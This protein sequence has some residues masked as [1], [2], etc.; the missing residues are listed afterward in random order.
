MQVLVELFPAVDITR[1]GGQ[2]KTEIR[3]LLAG[4]NFTYR[5]TATE[6]MISISGVLR[7]KKIQ[8]A[9][10]TRNVLMAKRK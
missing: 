9:F 4:N 10:I 7:K 2:L 6:H 1:I 5:Q 3:S 8:L